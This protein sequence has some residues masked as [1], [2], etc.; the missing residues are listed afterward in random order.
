M[1]NHMRYFATKHNV[2]DTDRTGKAM[3]TRLWKG[4]SSVFELVYF[5]GLSF[6]LPIHEA[7]YTTVVPC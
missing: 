1:K 2:L 5:K 4:L 7:M 6:I 3:H